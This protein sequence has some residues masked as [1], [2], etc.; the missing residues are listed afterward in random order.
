[1]SFGAVAGITLAIA[2]VVVM[3]VALMSYVS[4]LVKN[5]YQIKVELRSDVENAI[6][7]MEAEMERRSKALRKEMGDDS[8]QVR[9]AVR[10]DNERRVKE[11]EERLQGTAKELHDAG[12]SDKV[13]MQKVLSDLQGRLKALETDMAAVKGELA[14]RAAIARAL[15]EKDRAETTEGRD[16]A[17]GEAQPAEA[18]AAA[19]DESPKT[20]KAAPAPATPTSAPTSAPAQSGP[21]APRF[22]Y[23]DFAAS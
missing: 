19:T 21:G 3:G 4:S 17:E 1:M 5:A 18:D 16:G 22:H 13:A 15:H 2:V 6:A 20:Q 9:E 7:R 11:I 23:N 10:L 14:R 12:R 8:T